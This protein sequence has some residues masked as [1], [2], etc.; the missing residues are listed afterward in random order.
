MRGSVSY[1]PDW[2]FDIAIVRTASEFLSLTQPMDSL[3][4]KYANGLSEIYREV[5]FEEILEPAEEI[6]R[7]LSEVKAQHMAVE[8]LKDFSYKPTSCCCPI[9]ASA[10]RDSR[11]FGFL[12]VLSIFMPWLIAPEVTII[13][14]I[15]LFII[16]TCLDKSF[17]MRDDAML[18]PLINALPIFKTTFLYFLAMF[19]SIFVFPFHPF[20][21]I[22]I[23]S[24]FLLDVFSI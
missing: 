10:C 5:Y 8:L 21:K 17:I 22:L 3:A 12:L 6:L 16:D 24:F 7:F 20:Y 19:F 18:L 2:I 1:A 9:A 23:F 13:I 11:S 4:K 14:W 15:P